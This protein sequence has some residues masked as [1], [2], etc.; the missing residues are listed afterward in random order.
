V[1]VVDIS[2]TEAM[3]G[4]L[5][6]LFSK[7]KSHISG[8]E[9]A[10]EELMQ[11]GWEKEKKLNY[12]PKLSYEFNFAQYKDVRDI[13]ETAYKK[14]VIRALSSI[15]MLMRTFMEFIAD[16]YVIVVTGEETTINDDFV[17]ISHQ[18]FIDI[19]VIYK[20]AIIELSKTTQ[21]Y[22][23]PTPRLD[24]IGTV[25]N[26]LGNLLC[27]GLVAKRTH[28][29]AKRTHP[30]EIRYIIV[31]PDLNEG[32]KYLK[33]SCEELDD[34]PSCYNIAALYR[35][36]ADKFDRE[37]ESEMKIMYYQTSIT[38]SINFFK[39]VGKMIEKHKQ[40]EGE[41]MKFFRNLLENVEHCNDE[42][43][44][45]SPTE[46]SIRLEK[47]AQTQRELQQFIDDEYHSRIS[48]QKTDA[49][50]KQGGKTLSMKYDRTSN[51]SRNY[52]KGR[53][54]KKSRKGRSKK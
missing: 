46:E 42:I 14:G 47:H 5:S 35:N 11:Q 12:Y 38:S 1:Y 6:S 54:H 8:P 44:E 29:I 37:R 30:R 43:Y 27:Y 25:H 28:L 20:K 3:S 39:N 15:G 48:S 21:T 45:L 9:T 51:K 7:V 52:K 17:V 34:Y 4:V 19:I 24:L 10:P 36:A 32:I 40:N 49:A 2:E 53:R 50:G 23:D 22:T 41:I 33:Y 31:E 16:T 13:Y 18:F 26:N